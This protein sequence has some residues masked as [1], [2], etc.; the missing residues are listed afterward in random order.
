M[1]WNTSIN[2]SNN[3]LDNF[4][5][6]LST[7]DASNLSLL[8]D[9]DTVS[10]AYNKLASHYS[11]VP[12]P[13]LTE[14]YIYDKENNILGRKVSLISVEID[15]VSWKLLLLTI[16]NI[17]FN[18]K[19]LFVHN[20]SLNFNYLND[21]E[22]FLSK[23]FLLKSLTLQYINWTDIKEITSLTLNDFMNINQINMNKNYIESEIKLENIENSKEDMNDYNLIDNNIYEEDTLENELI[24]NK[25]ES[26]KLQKLL[27][28]FPENQRELISNYIIT[29]NK[30]LQDSNQLEYLS[31]KSNNL[32]SLILNEK[33]F[34]TLPNSPK[35]TTINY[36]MNSS[37][38]GLNLSGNKLNTYSINRLIQ[39]GLKFNM[40][41]KY[42]DL[43]NNY[44]NGKFL[45]NNI[46]NLFYYGNN[47]SKDDDNLIKNYNKKLSEKNKVIKD[48][49]K[50]RKKLNLNEINEINLSLFN[51]EKYIRNNL[52]INTIF[53]NL[54]LKNNL[55]NFLYLKNYT[56]SST[57]FDQ[58]N[59][60]RDENDE[61]LS[62]Q[63]S[64]IF[65][66]YNG[67][68]H[69][70]LNSKFIQLFKIL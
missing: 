48:I 23:Y 64:S 10:H 42:F 59:N 49:N 37:L 5:D 41:L 52:F 46:L 33:L 20:C 32:T 27:L 34:A 13:Y 19:E 66:N 22:I 47:I 11:I 62:I 28:I 8:S 63:I 9:C 26:E 51:I 58:L 18:V 53:S 39:D 12:C 67:N 7:N 17:K 16:F 61:N 31:L 45:M 43:S 35:D 3:C 36:S 25:K 4:N 6:L 21:L 1:I 54:N 29:L 14:S 55:I 65:N 40:K 60:L 68:Y 50:K 38:I 57:I 56:S 24:Y 30:I 15:L 70:D 69:D 44:Y 2:N